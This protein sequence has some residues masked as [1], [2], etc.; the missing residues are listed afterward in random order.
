MP[1]GRSI[2]SLPARVCNMSSPTHR[3]RGW[4]NW[5]DTESEHTLPHHILNCSMRRPDTR[6][7]ISI[8]FKVRSTQITQQQLWEYLEFLELIYDVPP[9]SRRYRGGW[10]IIK[11][12]HTPLRSMIGVQVATWLYRLP[13]PHTYIMR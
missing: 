8:E 2:K 3:G 12:A 1:S 9:R 13:T 5:K 11:L 4:R 7:R 6:P 10:I